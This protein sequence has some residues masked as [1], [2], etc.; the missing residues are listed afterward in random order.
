MQQMP[1]LPFTLAATLTPYPLP[2]LTAL[3]PL[4]HHGLACFLPYFKNA[5]RHAPH[6]HAA[7]FLPLCVTLLPSL[8][9]SLPPLT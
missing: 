4:P 8:Q 7:P 1:H 3:N 5:N 9:S 6:S 2:P